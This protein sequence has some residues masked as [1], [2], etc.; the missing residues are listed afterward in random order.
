MLP[1]LET[2]NIT[3]IKLTGLE[4]PNLCKSFLKLKTLDISHCAVTNLKGI[5]NLKNL[6]VLIIRGLNLATPEDMD[7]LFGCKKLRMLDFAKS[8]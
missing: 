2:L 4:F 6:E 8:K 5:S 1:N 7:D 3:G